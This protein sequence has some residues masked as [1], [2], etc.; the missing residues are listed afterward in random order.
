MVTGEEL[1]KYSILVRGI[2]AKGI[3]VTAYLAAVLMQ[4]HIGKEVSLRTMQR[5]MAKRLRGLGA[6]PR[7]LPLGFTFEMPKAG[8]VKELPEA[9]AAI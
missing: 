8:R 7:A 9:A 1:L 4:E 2:L 6:K 5:I 3:N